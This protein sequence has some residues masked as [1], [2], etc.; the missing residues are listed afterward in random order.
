MIPVLTMFRAA[1]GSL[2]RGPQP[3]SSAATTKAQPNGRR[4][5]N[6]SI[7]I[8]VAVILWIAQSLGSA[9]P[10][11]MSFVGPQKPEALLQIRSRRSCGLSAAGVNL[12]FDAET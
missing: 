11:A 6:R 9:Q 1:F 10:F 12:V 7:F 8:D 3:I 5:I 2:G 4:D